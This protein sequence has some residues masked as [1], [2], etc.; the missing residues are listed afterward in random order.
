MYHD[1]RLSE[2]NYKLLNNI[3][4]CNSFQYKCKSR[5]NAK[6]E[7]C[8]CEK[9]DIKHLI[10]EC[11]SVQRLWQK[12][13]SILNFDVCWKHIIIFRKKKIKNCVFKYNYIIIYVSFVIYK[14]KMTCRMKENFQS[15]NT[16]LIFFQC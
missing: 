11:L 5:S 16:L 1:K 7:F 9:E 13:N 3:L 4:N 10:F 6:C 12:L 15:C 2:F 8:P 14:Y